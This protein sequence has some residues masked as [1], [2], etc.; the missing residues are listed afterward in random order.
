MNKSRFFCF[1]VSIEQM[2]YIYCSTKVLLISQQVKSQ[3]NWGLF[4]QRTEKIEFLSKSF[5]SDSP[6]KKVLIFVFFVIS[7]SFSYVLITLSEIKGSLWL[8]KIS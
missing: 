8:N 5:K 3:Q 4:N 1:L 2:S 7:K 6:I